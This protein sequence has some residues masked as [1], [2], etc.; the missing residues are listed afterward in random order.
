MHDH[1]KS[2]LAYVKRIYEQY[3]TGTFFQKVINSMKMLKALG[4]GLILAVWQG[5][6][7]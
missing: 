2:L 7:L 1:Y 5:L 6:G 3:P 4:R